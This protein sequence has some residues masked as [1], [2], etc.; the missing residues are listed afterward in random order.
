MVTAAQFTSRAN[1]QAVQRAARQ[2]L[3]KTGYPVLRNID[4]SVSDD[5]IVL[6]GRVPSFYHKQLAQETV[7]RTSQEKQIVNHIEVAS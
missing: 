7:R 2:R 5:R 6:R 1:A 4:C 3:T